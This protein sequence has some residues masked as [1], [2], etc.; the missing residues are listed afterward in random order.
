MGASEGQQTLRAILPQG[1]VQRF[2]RVQSA[3]RKKRKRRGKARTGSVLE[4]GVQ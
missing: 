4:V 1:V 2:L 3:F